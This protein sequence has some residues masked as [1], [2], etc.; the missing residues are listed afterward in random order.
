MV[1]QGKGA[2]VAPLLQLDLGTAQLTIQALCS[3]QTRL[4]FF[5]HNVHSPDV[6][7]DQQPSAG[8]SESKSTEKDHCAPKASCA[9]FQT[10][11]IA[12]AQ[13]IQDACFHYTASCKGLIQQSAGAFAAQK[14]G[15]SNSRAGGQA[16]SCFTS[17]TVRP[18]QLFSRESL[19]CMSDDQLFVCLGA[20]T[21]MLD[22]QKHKTHSSREEVTKL[23][24]RLGVQE[25]AIV[26]LIGSVTV[27]G[28][29]G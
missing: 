8:Q 17:S 28:Q 2:T 9:G 5:Q 20:V 15:H 24:D 19:L 23:Q 7:T 13:G 22:H 26:R 10:A 25:M 6:C 21:A 14:P 3:P 1:P 12:I 4:R 11:A 29:D 16:A 18:L 27:P